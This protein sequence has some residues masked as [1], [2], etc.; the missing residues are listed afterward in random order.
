MDNMVRTPSTCT[1]RR[2]QRARVDMLM[3]EDMDTV[4]EDI[5]TTEVIDMYDSLDAE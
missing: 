1:C 3:G 4:I 5:T 2:W